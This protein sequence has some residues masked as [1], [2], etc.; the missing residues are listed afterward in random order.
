MFFFK[1]GKVKYTLEHHIMKYKYTFISKSFRFL[2]SDSKSLDSKRPTTQPLKKKKKR[3]FPMAQWLR[4]R[5]PMQGT[6]VRSLVQEDPT[7]CGATKPVRH[8]YWACTLQPVRHNYWS[9][10][11]L[12]PACPN[13]WAHALQPLKPMHSRAH[14]PQLLKPTGC[15]YWSLRA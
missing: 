12:E 13:N 2:I 9:P 4:I 1:R 14:V 6:Q 5:L 8:N 3:T 11:A 15:N 10:H 7:C